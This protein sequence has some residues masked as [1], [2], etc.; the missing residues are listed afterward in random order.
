MLSRL[1][2]EDGQRVENV[3][4]FEQDLH[5]PRLV[6]PLP[7]PRLIPLTRILPGTVHARLG[8]PLLSLA[9]RLVCCRP[10]LLSIA[11][12]PQYNGIF[13]LDT[14]PHVAGSA[15]G[16]LSLVV[17]EQLFDFDCQELRLGRP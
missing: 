11:P 12:D 5:V 8:T 6:L 15:A 1:V 16:L 3:G 13:L 7:R 9:T 17:G 10:P 4:Q 14:I 2:D